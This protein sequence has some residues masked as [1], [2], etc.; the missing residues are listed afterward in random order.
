M[1]KPLISVIIP[2]YNEEEHIRGLLKSIFSQSLDPKSFEVIIVDGKSQDGTK[3]EALEYAKQH[4]GQD[5][6]VI[7]NPRRR[8]PFAFNKGIK[9]SRGEFIT[10]VGAHSELDKHWLRKSLKT[11]QEAPAE[12]MAIGGRWENV[13]SDSKASKAIAYTTATFWGGGMSSYRYNKDPHYADTVVYGMYRREVFDKI[14]LFDTNFLIGQD[15]ELNLRIKKAGYRM[16]CNPE[17]VAKYK[18]RP[19]FRRFS[20]QMYE[21][22]KARIRM[23]H[24]HRE[25]KIKQIIPLGLVLYVPLGIA[26]S[27]VSPWFLAPLALHTLLTVAMSLKRPATALHNIA[28]F[29]ITHYV[30]GTGMLAGLV[31]IIKGKKTCP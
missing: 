2:V 19:D 18:V 20:K 28:S 5:I 26:L 7:D 17:I 23:L 3:R 27:F 13:A 4:K 1:R 8:T 12:V 14:G 25:L 21:Y 24:K 31:D 15:G 6:K 9:A 22:G 10:I 30:F 11:I 29:T 16:F